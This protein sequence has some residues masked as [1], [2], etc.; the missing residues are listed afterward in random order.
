MSL[1]RDDIADIKQLMESVVAANNK[2]LLEEMNRR[3]DEAD[4]KFDLINEKLNEHDEKFDEILNAVGTDLN[5][6]AA[7]L[8]DHETRITRLEKKIA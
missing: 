6:Q 8:D 7:H 4:V 1:T 5:N 2:V 3:F